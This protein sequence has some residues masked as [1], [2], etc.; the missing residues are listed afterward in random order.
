[1]SAL[2]KKEV[3]QV[4]PSGLSK[5]SWDLICNL[6]RLPDIAAVVSLNGD[7]NRVY[8]ISIPGYAD[9]VLRI[10]HP[11]A[12]TSQKILS[13]FLVLKHLRKNTDLNVPSPIR[14]KDGRF[15]TTI[16][17]NDGAGPWRIS[18]FSYIDGEVLSGKQP[19]SENMFL[20]GQALG[21]LDIALENADKAIK[22]T[23]SKVRVRRYGKNIIKW[24]LVTFSQASVD[25]SFLNTV[26]A[27]KWLHP[28]L[29]EISKRLQSGCKEM[30]RSL[31]HQLLH[32]DTHLDNLIFD[33]SRIGILDFDNMAYGPRIYELAAPLPHDLWME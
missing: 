14:D 1:M 3:G 16:C 5:K 30:K 15:F 17:E 24:A 26:N 23:P 8:R 31:P 6:Y 19:T 7:D 11:D 12:G 28:T 21:Q 2:G 13:E 10:S 9:R 25:C 20:I 29:S 22:P 33:G 4:I 32:L 18:M 27:E